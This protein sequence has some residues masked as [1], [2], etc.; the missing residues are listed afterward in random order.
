MKRE[1]VEELVEVRPLL[2][3]QIQQIDCGQCIGCRLKYSR[4]WADRLVLES[5]QYPETNTW[6]ITLTYSD[7]A[8]QLR[9]KHDKLLHPSFLTRTDL[10]TGVIDTVPVLYKRDVELFM[11]RLRKTFAEFGYDNIRYYCAGE[12]GDKNG[13]PHFH[14]VLFN[15]GFP[16]LRLSDRCYSEFGEMFESD[17]LN[18]CWSDNVGSNRSPDYR[19]IGI[20]AI[21]RFSWHFGAYIARYVVKK[22]VG[23]SRKAFEETHEFV[24]PETGKLAEYVHEFVRMSTHPGIAYQYYDEH[25]DQIYETDTVFVPDKKG[26][27]RIKPPRYFDKLYFTQE[28][29]FRGDELKAERRATAIAGRILEL[30]QVTMTEA[31]YLAVQEE[32]Q[33]QRFAKLYRKL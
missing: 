6:C 26:I 5:M 32:A 11:K 8:F 12:Y 13:R 7:E 14:M 10:E 27:R 33:V 23:K 30:E 28:D 25:K 3:N 16:D 22:Q 9:D 29:P 15:I 31:D 24:D 2:E 17:L 1:E 19:P 21:N 18:R 20:A 4:S